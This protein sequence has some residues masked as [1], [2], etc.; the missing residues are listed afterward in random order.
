MVPST[1]G[2]RL[3]VGGA[4]DATG[5]ARYRIASIVTATGLVD[6]ALAPKLNKDVLAV[7]YAQGSV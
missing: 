4:F 5:T 3:Y 7:A 2:S 1:D 6:P